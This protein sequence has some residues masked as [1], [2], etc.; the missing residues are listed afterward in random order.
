MSSFLIGYDISNQVQ[1]QLVYWTMYLVK[2]SMQMQMYAGPGPFLAS[3][4][5]PCGMFAVV[6]LWGGTGAGLVRGWARTRAGLVRGLRWWSH[7]TVR[8]L[9]DVAI[10][11]GLHAR[12]DAHCTV[13][14]D[15]AI[16]AFPVAD[17]L[18]HLK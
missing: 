11:E 15:N 13:V 16:A 5:V 10:K 12:S 17:L 18:A 4:S 1:K 6:G 3:S 8:L 14:F 2:T 9:I 7:R